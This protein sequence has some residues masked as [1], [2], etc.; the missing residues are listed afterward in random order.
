MN[1]PGNDSHSSSRTKHFI[2][3]AFFSTLLGQNFPHK[4]PRHIGKPHIPAIM[5]IGELLVV[6]AEQMEESSVEVVDGLF[7][8]N[9]P[10]AEV[11]RGPD[12]RP[13]LSHPAGKPDRKSEGV[14]V[15]AVHAL[16]D[17]HPSELSVPGDHS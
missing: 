2:F 5:A 15:P 16:R 12:D 10:V 17:G 4:V 7:V 14:V 8:F 9:G 11:V 3:A 1:A 13:R 6:E